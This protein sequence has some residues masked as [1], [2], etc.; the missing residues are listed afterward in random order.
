MPWILFI[1]VIIAATVIQLG[2]ISSLAFSL[3]LSLNLLLAVVVVWAS[4]RSLR[5]A[6]TAGFGLGLILDFFSTNLFVYCISFSAL[7]FFVVYFKGKLIQDDYV[8]LGLAAFLGTLLVF[9]VNSFLIFLYSERITQISL[10]ALL[11]SGGGNAFL[12]LILAPGA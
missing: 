8:Y 3:N 2:F 4:L 10:L 11:L 12:V 5:G 9:V 6:W 7:A 1:F